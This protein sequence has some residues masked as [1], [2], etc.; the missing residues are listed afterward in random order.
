MAKAPAKNISKSLRGQRSGGRSAETVSVA[1]PSGR[2][3]MTAPGEGGVEEAPGTNRNQG[4]DR[5]AQHYVAPQRRFG[6]G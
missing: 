1:E 3:S 2:P 4:G 6:G 5:S